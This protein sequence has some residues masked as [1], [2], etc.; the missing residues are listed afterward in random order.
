[1]DQQMPDDDRYFGFAVGRKGK[2]FTYHTWPVL[3]LFVTSMKGR[4][5]YLIPTDDANAAKVCVTL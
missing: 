1:M 4:Y 3:H 5:G 2:V